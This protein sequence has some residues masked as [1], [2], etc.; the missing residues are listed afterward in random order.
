MENELQLDD[1]DLFLTGLDIAAKESQSEDLADLYDQL[2][3]F[4]DESPKSVYSLV[5][6][7]KP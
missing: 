6:R 2:K 5:R 7:E 1:M 4:Y 3:D